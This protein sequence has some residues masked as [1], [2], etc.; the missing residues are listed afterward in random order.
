MRIL[1]AITTYERLEYLQKCLNSIIE[2]SQPHHYYHVVINDDGSKDGTRLWL[3]T[4][5]SLKINNFSFHI[6]YSN[7]KGV[8][9]A[10]NNLILYAN[11]LHYDFGFKM[12]DDVFVTRKGWEDL[13]INC[14][15]DH[16]VHFNSS[17]S[18]GFKDPITTN[19]ISFKTSIMN[20]QGAFWTF[21]PKMLKEV[22]F[23]DT[24]TMGKRGHGHIDFTCRAIKMGFGYQKISE[25]TPRPVDALWSE[26]YINYQPRDGYKLT[27]NYEEEL[28]IAIK[29]SPAKI[30]LIMD[31]KRRYVPLQKSVL[32][33]FFEHIYVLNLPSRTDRK[34]RM[35]SLF[36]KHNIEVEFFDAIDGKKHHTK[37]DKRNAGEVGCFLSHKAII[38]D[39]YE[40]GYESILIL[41]DDLILHKDFHKVCLNLY[42]I[43]KNEWDMIYL[44][45]SDYNFKENTINSDF[46]KPYYKGRLIDGTF[47][48]G[49][50]KDKIKKIHE[51]RALTRNLPI[52]TNYHSLDSSS[53]KTFVMNPMPII[54]DVKNSDIRSPRDIKTNAL[55]VNWNLKNYNL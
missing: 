36:S 4:I 45:A 21:T 49:I 3:K 16:L 39:A 19:K 5:S 22:G 34:E 17:W 32:N 40:K 1:I 8:H 29:E 7:N 55:N 11:S 38:K 23:I 6:T 25:N 47:A 10:D 31:W 48:Y 41:E 54:A 46:S 43:P 12:D 51:N 26:M 28:G 52:D 42:S 13:Y 15:V 53:E 35:K 14:D 2:H 18:N 37:S 20:V 24:K 33:H 30:S 44:G 50:T 27:P 9:H